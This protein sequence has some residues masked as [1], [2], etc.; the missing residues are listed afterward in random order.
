[1]VSA[2]LLIAIDQRRFSVSRT[3]DLYLTLFLVTSC[4]RQ[5]T[6]TLPIGFFPRE[7]ITAR[8]GG[9]GGTTEFQ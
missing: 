4:A 8:I 1:M 2:A 9:I 3:L 6:T 5:I 7:C